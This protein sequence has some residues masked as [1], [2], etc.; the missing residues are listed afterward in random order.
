MKNL[1]ATIAIS[2]LAVGMLGAVQDVRAQDPFGLPLP[3]DAT[4][5]GAWITGT[6]AIYNNPLNYNVGVGT[7]GPKARLGLEVTSTTRNWLAFQR[8]GNTSMWKIYSPTDSDRMQFNYSID[9]ATTAWNMFNLFPTG[10]AAINTDQARGRLNIDVKD[11]ISDWIALSKLSSEGFYKIHRNADDRMTFAYD[12][13][14]GGG[15][16]WDILEIDE[17]GRVGINGALDDGYTRNFNVS[18]TS[19]FTDN[20]RMESG[21]GD[22]LTLANEGDAAEWHIH[23]PQGEDRITIG[24]TDDQ[25]T[26]AWNYFSILDNGNIAI[27]SSSAPEKLSVD[28]TILAE[29][30]LVKMSQDWPDYVFDEGY[31]LRSLDEVEAFIAEHKHLPGVPS[32]Q[33]VSEEPVALGEMNRVMMEKI[34]EL[35]L[36]MIDLQKENR[37]LARRISELKGE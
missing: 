12:P 37:D 28:G 24:H 27:G 10:S 22:W 6:S 21:W 18:G 13:N 16:K 32:G 1:M 14:N 30:V 31:D 34:E 15:I 36:H 26:T 29:E 7:A 2:I 25:G 9:P 19:V 8:P 11:G 23:N 17:S 20:V 4:T 33:T 5:A 3:E 35:T